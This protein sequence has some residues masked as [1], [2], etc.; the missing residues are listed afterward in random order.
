MSE[1]E[2]YGLLTVEAV[3]GD[4]ASCVCACGKTVLRAY[5]QLKSTVARGGKPCCKDCQKRLR[6]GVRL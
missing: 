2:R 4:K 3:V 1:R 5:R 6:R